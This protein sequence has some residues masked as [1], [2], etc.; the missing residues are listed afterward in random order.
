ME[1]DVSEW[2][3]AFYS[4]EHDA[5]KLLAQVSEEALKILDHSASAMKAIHNQDCC[6]RVAFE[7]NFCALSSVT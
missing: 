5:H 7:S 3:H 2:T 6:I 4:E 1:T